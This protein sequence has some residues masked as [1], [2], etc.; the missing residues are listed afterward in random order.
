MKRLPFAAF[1]VPAL[2]TETRLKAPKPLKVEVLVRT[3]EPGPEMGPPFS[4][5]TPLTVRVDP[6]VVLERFC[7][8]SVVRTIGLEMRRVPSEEMTVVVRVP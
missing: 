3:S 6:M 5:K 1:K 8:V 2:E 7:R 4:V